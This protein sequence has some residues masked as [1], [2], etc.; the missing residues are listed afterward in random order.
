M[1]IKSLVVFYC[2]TFFL[3]SSHTHAEELA[4]LLLDPENPTPKSSTQVTL[5]SY[6]FDVNTAMITW[7]INKKTVLRGMGE[8][9]LTVQTGSI[10]QSTLVTVLAENAQGISVEQQINITPSSVTI[11]YEA[12]KSYVPHF[13]EGRS[14][15]AD[16]ATIHVTALPQVSDAGA[17]VPASSFSYVWYVNDSVVQSASGFGKQSAEIRLDYLRNETEIKVLVRSPLGNAVSKTITVV[18]RAVMPL[19]YLYDPV[20]GPDMSTV[21]GKR[22]ET[23]KDFTFSLEPFYLS[24]KDKD[25]E[26]SY[27]WLLDDLPSTPLNG[28]VLSFQLKENG[29]GTKM[30]NIA[31]TGPNAYLQKAETTVEIIF[32][33]RR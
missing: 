25:G 20:L 11:L 13:Y 15:P 10:G 3:F 30:L 21:I 14:L 28:R 22:F 1:K 12:R 29:Y 17:L 6:Y 18:P 4:T 24:S 2:L 5:Q 8:K 7:Q 31:V 32:D 19:L 23:Q 9:K 27:I 16:G 33:T 26:P